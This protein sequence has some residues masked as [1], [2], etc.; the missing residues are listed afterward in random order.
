MIHQAAEWK[1]GRKAGAAP[2]APGCRLQ[3]AVIHAGPRTRR[4]GPRPAPQCGMRWVLAITPGP[5]GR[6]RRAI[7]RAV[8]LLLIVFIAT[9]SVQPI[10]AAACSVQR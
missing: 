4:G 7:A 5:A 6:R 2:A 3:S 9:H 1:P 10:G 8:L